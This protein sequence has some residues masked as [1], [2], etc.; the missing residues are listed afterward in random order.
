M[1][2]FS[3]RIRFITLH[4]PEKPQMNHATELAHYDLIDLCVLINSKE[5]GLPP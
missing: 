5:R 4:P 1:A 3:K 2:C